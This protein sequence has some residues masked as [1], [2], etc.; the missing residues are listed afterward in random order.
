M[1][2]FRFWIAAA[3]AGQAAVAVLPSG[4]D[5]LLNMAEVLPAAWL[6]TPDQFPDADAVQVD[7][8]ERVAYASDGTA[9]TWYDGCARVLTEQ[10]RR[11]ASTISLSFYEFY[12]TVDVHRVEIYKPDGR[13][14][15]VDIA[16]LS[17]VAVAADQMGRNIYDPGHKVLSISVPGLETGDV[18][19]VLLRST[20]IRSRVPGHWWNI[21]TFESDRPILRSVY[22][23]DA[24]S[25]RPL[26]HRVVRDEIPGTIEYSEETTANG[27]RHRWIARRVPQM[28]PEPGMPDAIS[29]VQRVLVST[30]EDW[31][32][33]SRW[34]WNLSQPRLEA[35]SDDLRRATADLTAGLSGERARIE[36]LFAFVS[37]KVRYA[38][39]TRETEAPG[40][41]PHDVERT[42]RDRHGV[43]RDKAALLVAMLRMSGIE[44]FPVLIHMGPR[45]DPTVPLPYFNHAIAAARLRDGTTL[46]M[47]PTDEATRE[48]LPAYLANRSYLIASPEGEPLRTSPVAPAESNLVRIVLDS[49][50]EGDGRIRGQA[51]VVF[52]GIN[53]NIYRGYFARRKP[54]ERRRFFESMAQ[55]ALPGCRLSDFRIEPDDLQDRSHPLTARLSFEAAD[56]AV[57]GPA[58]ALLSPPSLAGAFGVLH[59]VLQDT[60]LERRRFPL[61]TQ[62]ACGVEE[63]SSFAPGPSLRD[64]IV[65][66]AFEEIDTSV[67]RWRRR[68][69]AVGDRLTADTRVLLRTAELTPAEYLD[70]KA[71]LRR[72]EGER[73]RRAVYEARPLS[74]KPETSPAPAPVPAGVDVAI[75]EHETDVSVLG[76]GAWAT[77]NRVVQRILTYAGV[78]AASELKLPYVEGHGGAEVLEASVTSPDGNVHVLAPSELTQMDQPW[79]PLAPRYPPGRLLVATLPA[80]GPGSLVTYRT[81][82]TVSN[83]LFF[84]A[85]VAIDGFEPVARRVVRLHHGIGVPVRVVDRAGEVARAAHTNGGAVRLE[86]T[87]SSLPAVARETAMP[88]SW[89]DRPTLWFS[90]GTWSNDGARLLAALSAAAN[91]PAAARRAAEIVQGAGNAAAKADRVR[92]AVATM[93]RSA[94]PPWSA[95]PL[96]SVSAAD[97]TLLDGYG[98]TADR[99]VVL[100]AMLA[101]LGLR[102]SFVLASKLPPGAVDAAWLS[103][104]PQADLFPEVLVRVDLDGGPPML[105]NDTDRYAAPGVAWH[106]GRLGVEPR[107]GAVEPL[108]DPDEF[109]D[110]KEIRCE[111]EIARDGAA[112]LR[113]TE[114]LFGTHQAEFA[115]QIAEMSPEELRRRHQEQVAEIAQ[116]AESLAPARHEIEFHPA[117]EEIEVR[118]PRF[119]VRA[120]GF[121]HFTLP[122]APPWMPGVSTDARAHALY[123]PDPLRETIEISVRLPPGVGAAEI[124]PAPF[125]WSRPGV[126]RVSVATRLDAAAGRLIYR[127][128]VELNATRVSADL[129]AELADLNRRLRHPS[130]TT[131]LLRGGLDP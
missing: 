113:R 92:R 97:R 73:R 109:R 31:P 106:A 86:W 19:R 121:V 1:R 83:Q 130:M 37:Q 26:R 93:I 129:Y 39:V 82:A 69:E 105:L 60:G 120:D 28:F 12:S 57:R 99:A 54:D 35:A 18:L 128:E 116:D 40:Y 64:P 23:I 52:H 58:L 5:G 74:A 53:D 118:L 36:A 42:F 3:Q 78:K 51:S 80:V 9:V 117:V 2:L 103:D 41:E 104:A 94:G 50:A 55:H 44:G 16:A 79:T 89:I 81:V 123:W 61:V 43:C 20:Q 30:C 124:V 62:H 6:A 66:P 17:R 91:G 96:T 98:N 68:W 29:V 100:Y 110:R 67:F 122:V 101:A 27:R 24:P 125:E 112:R 88:P 95:L 102:P 119:A 85:R 25:E 32:S 7:E 63:R 33:I 14:V 11:E 87:A 70:L 75:E 71:A 84:H 56:P 48:L 21:C 76:P 114:R 49:A 111:I 47:D 46:L 15:P 59:S 38:G 13:Q 107:T 34:Y 131:V 108:P 10:G 65:I 72:V 4:S 45:R 126:G 77:T 90:S 8:I 115:R 22:E 127:R